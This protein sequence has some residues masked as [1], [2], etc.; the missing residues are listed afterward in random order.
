M[1]RRILHAFALLALLA[2]P[3]AAQPPIAAFEG[4]R[5][6]LEDVVRAAS[7]SNSNAPMPLVE[8]ETAKGMSYD[9]QV[10]Y[11]N[12][13]FQKRQLN[14][15]YR[16]EERAPRHSQA[17][18]QRWAREEA[19]DRLSVGQV[20]DFRGTIN[21]P[22]VLQQPEYKSKREQVDRLYASHT[23]AGGG[24]GTTEYAQIQSSTKELQDQLR[25][26]LDNLTS[27]Q[28]LYARKFLEGLRYDARFPAGT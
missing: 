15:S 1:S 10:K 18:Y 19:P 17:D 26:N 14:R 16:E 28:Y 13:Y 7:Q 25:G 11:T 4:L 22:V 2:A 8:Y 20:D 23:A 24:M 9:N 27:E 21:W 5:R 6:G 12:T 3:V